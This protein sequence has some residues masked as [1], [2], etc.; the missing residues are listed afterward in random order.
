VVKSKIS[1]ELGYGSTDIVID[2]RPAI[3]Q[4]I[5]YDPRRK[6]DERLESL[7]ELVQDERAEKDIIYGLTWILENDRDPKVRR[8]VHDMMR[9]YRR[10]GS[11]W[12]VD[13][14]RYT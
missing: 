12:D 8:L 14:S 13:L 4:E 3:L 6:P 1:L 2:R 10:I 9:S 7:K 5:G 11:F